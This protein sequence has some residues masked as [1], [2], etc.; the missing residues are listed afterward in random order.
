MLKRQDVL[1]AAWESYM[2]ANKDKD[3]AAF[4][5]GW[6]DARVAALKKAGLG[7]P[8]PTWE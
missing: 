3:D 2:G 5:K 7:A 8:F 6:Q 4:V 1:A